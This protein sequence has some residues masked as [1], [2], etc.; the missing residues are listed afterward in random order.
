MLKRLNVSEGDELIA[1]EVPGGYLLTTHDLEAQRQLKVAQ[2]VME[3]YRE[4]LRL[5]ANRE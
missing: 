4:T 2:E 3:E 1:V 5:L